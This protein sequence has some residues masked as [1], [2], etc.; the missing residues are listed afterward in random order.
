MFKTDFFKKWE[1]LKT[2]LSTKR[3]QTKSDIYLHIS[4]SQSR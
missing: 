2:A 1:N 4:D 3:K